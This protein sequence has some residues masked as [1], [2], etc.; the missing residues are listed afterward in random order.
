[1]S[2]AFGYLL[3]ACCLLMVGGVCWRMLL[4]GFTCFALVCLVVVFVGNLVL[5]IGAMCWVG[6]V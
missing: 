3:R 4:V 1:M 5:T 2:L 6:F